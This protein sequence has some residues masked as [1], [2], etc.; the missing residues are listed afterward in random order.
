MVNQRQEHRLPVDF[1]TKA[2]ASVHRS[3]FLIVQ[4]RTDIKLQS[5]MAMGAAYTPLLHRFDMTLKSSLT[6]TVA[7]RV[8]PNLTKEIIDQLHDD[9]LSLRHCSLVSK[10]W[11]ERALKWLFAAIVMQITATNPW[12]YL[13]W[14]GEP[15]PGTGIGVSRI[16]PVQILTST[17]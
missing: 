1:R 6:A 13:H 14:F 8:A 16:E 9:P 17:S 5:F 4:S 7:I 2:N 15:T 11:R 3:R 12:S 10:T